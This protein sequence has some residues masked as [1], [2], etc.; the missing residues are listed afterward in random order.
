MCLILEYLAWR[1]RSSHHCLSI[2]AKDASDIERCPHSVHQILTRICLRW[3]S[4]RTGAVHSEESATKRLGTH[5][6]ML[7]R[8]Y[9]HPQMYNMYHNIT[10]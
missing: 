9:P 8:L 7:L 5:Y 4:C 3:V 1:K 10:F 2:T 6:P